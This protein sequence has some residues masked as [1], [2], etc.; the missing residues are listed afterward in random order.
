MATV[1]STFTA[2]GVS[3]TL[4]VDQPGETISIAISGTYDQEIQFERALTRDETAWEVVAGPYT[5][6]DATVAD[7]Y[8]TDRRKESFRIR[9]TA[10]VG[11]T[12]TYSISDG[13]FEVGKHV[14]DFGNPIYTATQAGV[15]FPG[16]MTV[17]GAVTLTGAL[18]QTGVLTTTSDLLV[19]GDIF[20]TQAAPAALSGAAQT[21]TA[22]NMLAGMITTTHTTTSTLTLPTGTVMD[23]GDGSVLTDGDSFDVAIINISASAGA[24]CTVTAATGF[25]I[26]GSA[27]I[28]GNDAATNDSEGI[29]RCVK[30]IANT[31]VAYRIA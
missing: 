21:A 5:V 11:G 25:T 26:V 12:A 24:D 13:D 9:A 2:V 7:S 27:L 22:A 20:R 17:D 3:G 31:Y 28:E 19:G 23:T 29:F 18:T 14:D 8:V 30:G 10:V 6:E 16:T 15:T 4:R 1:A